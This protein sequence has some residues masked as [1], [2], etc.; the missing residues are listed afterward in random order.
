M[1]FTDRYQAMGIP[2]PG[3]E[4]MCLG[5]CEGTGV[6]PIQFN[7]PGDALTLIEVAGKDNR[8]RE[9][10]DTAEAKNPSDDGWHFVACR[11]CQGTGKK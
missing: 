9:A 3:P 6:V 5:D 11:D 7:R 1:E 4:T 2:Y 10:W 8:Y